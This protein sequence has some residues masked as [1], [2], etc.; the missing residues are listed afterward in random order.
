MITIYV[1]RIRSYMHGFLH[2]RN[3]KVML[4]YVYQSEIGH[5]FC[6]FELERLRILSSSPELF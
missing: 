1:K 4:C 5:G 2:Y 3:N 6:H